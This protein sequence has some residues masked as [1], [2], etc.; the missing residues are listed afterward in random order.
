VRRVL[1][2]KRPAVTER[3]VSSISVTIPKGVYVSKE[4]RLIGLD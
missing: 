2:L 3:S 1:V 4:E